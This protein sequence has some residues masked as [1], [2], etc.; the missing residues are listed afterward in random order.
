MQDPQESGDPFRGQALAISTFW[1]NIARGWKSLPGRV[2]PGLWHFSMP[3]LE[4]KIR[5]AF[6]IKTRESDLQVMLH[7]TWGM[8][9]DR[10][11]KSKGRRLRL[12]P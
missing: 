2:V 3:F 9:C 10:A 4:A 1:P 7:C 5:R 11:E 8:Q 12:L 6:L